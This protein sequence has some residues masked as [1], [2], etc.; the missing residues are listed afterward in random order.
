MIMIMM[1]KQHDDNTSNKITHRTRAS[2]A[3]AFSSAEGLGFR[4]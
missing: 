4:V 2:T 3:P 1:I